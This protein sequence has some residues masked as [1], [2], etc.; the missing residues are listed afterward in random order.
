MAKTSIAWLLT[1]LLAAAAPRLLADVPAP[2]PASPPDPLQLLLAQGTSFGGGAGPRQRD[3]GRACETMQV[4]CQRGCFALPERDEQDAC[5][6]RCLAS[7]VECV[8]ECDARTVSLGAP[9][10]CGDVDP[11]SPSR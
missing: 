10:S 8:G 1:V 11:A 9:A 5:S 6:K 3:C 2:A 7:Y 4:N